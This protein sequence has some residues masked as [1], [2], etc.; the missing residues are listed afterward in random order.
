M[1]KILFGIAIVLGMALASSCACNHDVNAVEEEA[2]EAVDSVEVAP[3]DTLE[4]VAE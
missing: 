1:K 2:V 4:V 3:A